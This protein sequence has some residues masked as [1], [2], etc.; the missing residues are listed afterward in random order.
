MLHRAA[1]HPS[2]LAG[3]HKQVIGFL[4]CGAVISV[5]DRLLLLR[6]KF[7]RVSGILEIWGYL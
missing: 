4:R 7:Y 5:D 6:E 2:R 1:A 3:G